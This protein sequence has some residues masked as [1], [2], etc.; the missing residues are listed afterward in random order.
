[1]YNL[2]LLYFHFSPALCLFWYFLS[3]EDFQERPENPEEIFDSPRT[4]ERKKRWRKVEHNH[5]LHLL[6]PEGASLGAQVGGRRRAP[7]SRSGWGSPRG[8]WAGLGCQPSPG[9]RQGKH[10]EGKVGFFPGL[11]LGSIWLC[12]ISEASNCLS[13][14]LHTYVFLSLASPTFLHLNVWI[15]TLWVDT[16]KIKAY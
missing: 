9:Q 11:Y 15:I 12:V 8:Q 1:M 3:L 14:C 7:G 5:R 4:T 13:F 6:L 16:D 10:L 2:E